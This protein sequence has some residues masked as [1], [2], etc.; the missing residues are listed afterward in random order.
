MGIIFLFA[1][2]SSETLYCDDFK[3]SKKGK[4]YILH[5]KGIIGDKIISLDDIQS[6]MAFGLSDQVRWKYG[7]S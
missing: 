4:C 7:L 2:G 1:D 5:T 6:F 3:M